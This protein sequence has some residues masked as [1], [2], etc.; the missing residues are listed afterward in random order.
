MLKQWGNKMIILIGSEKGGTGKTTISTNICS[1][2]VSRGQDVLLIDTDKQGSA[3]TWCALRD[4]NK[5]VKRVPCVQKFGLGLAGEIQDLSN[6]YAN[7]IIDAGGRDSVELRSA[8]T[9]ADKIFI[10]LQASQF[11]VW[12]MA[13]MDNLLE[14][15]KAVNPKLQASVIINRASTHPSVSEAKDM[16][17]L[18]N[19]LINMK[20]IDQPIRDRIVYRKAAQRGLSIFEV[21]NPDT[22][23][24]LEFESFY[25][26]IRKSN[27]SK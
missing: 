17:E 10:P 25:N 15:M 22:K 13:A 5:S 12:T 18:S 4:E 16:L 1:L 19:D 20:M 7:I 2:M 24:V 21:D 14:L 11:D 23:A 26:H 6:R 27:E 9:V 3:S 8:M